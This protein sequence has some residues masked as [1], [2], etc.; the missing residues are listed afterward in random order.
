LHSADKIFS[1]LF[2]KLIGTPSAADKSAQLK[3]YFN[4]SGV[5]N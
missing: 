1:K 2:S 5:K 4:S 3:E